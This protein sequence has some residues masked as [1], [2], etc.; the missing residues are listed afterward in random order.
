MELK[1]GYKQTEVGVIPED[2][3]VKKLGECLLKNPDYGINAPAVPLSDTLPAY[4]RITDISNDGLFMKNDNVSVNHPQAELYFLEKGDLVFARTGASVGKT[5]LYNQE[6]GKLVFAGFL[7]RVRPRQKILDSKYLKFFTQTSL[8]WNWVGV[9]SMRSGQPGI[10]GHEYSQLPI[11]LPPTKAEQ[12]AIATALS[13]AD[14]LIQSLEKLI[15]KKRNIKQGAMQELLT[16]KNRLPEFDKNKGFKQTEVGM[17]PSDWDICEL[18]KIGK[19]KNGINKEKKDFGFGYPFVNLLNVFGISSIDSS[20]ELNFIN[21]NDEERKLYSL[22]K[23]DILFVR[24]SVKPSGVG[25]TTLI[26][27]NLPNT[28]FSGF[29]IRYRDEGQIS[30]E[31]KEY[32]FHENGFRNRLIANSTV[33]ANTNIN[34]EALKNLIVILPPT[35][36]KQTRIAAIL[37]D[38]DAEIATLETKLE[39]YK[40]IKQGMMQNLLTG[41]IRLI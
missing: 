10:N 29:L 33:S 34:Q 16:G 41:R 20:K 24:S 1:E 21:S 13:D 31:Y 19:F 8:Y 27:E 40:Q 15:A 38:M 37:S 18:G 5:Y 35:K 25:L 4:I 2:W 36:A 30:N 14:A 32:C 7:I 11:P 28:V 12:T 6:D 9:N 39:K 26:K 22:R 23:G 17:I 3:E